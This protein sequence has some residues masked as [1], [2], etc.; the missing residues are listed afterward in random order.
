MDLL[1]QMTTF[2]RV[3]DAG[4]LSAAAAPL[5]LSVPAVSRQIS[6]LEETLGGAL[7]LRS[8]RKVTTTPAGRRYYEHCQRVL[9]EVEAA[10]SSLKRG[11]VIEGQLVVTAPV[12]LGLARVSPHLPSL[13]AKHPG[14]MI[15]LRVEDHMVDLVSE[16]VDVAVRVGVAL[17]DSVSVVA[18]R[19]MSYRRIVVASPRY[20]EEFGEPRQ[21]RDLAQ[22]KAIAHIGVRGVATTWTLERKGVES[23]VE[24]RSAIRSNAPYVLRDA[25]IEG[26]GVALLPDW[27]AAPD[28]AA[29]RLRHVL[30]AWQTAPVVV[31]AVHRK[32]ARG[33]PRIKAFLDHLAAVYAAEERG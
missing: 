24:V 8:T 31:S 2:I 28:I 20:L 10:Q 9:R 30:R 17:P 29:G 16:G 4:S 21:P 15:D 3:V 7:L 26:A 19:L 18:R 22:H 33:A 13:V 1:A 12:T 32:E 6:A 5:Q 27:I 23:P 14:L 25:A 11:Q